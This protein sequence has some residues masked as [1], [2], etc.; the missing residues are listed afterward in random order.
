MLVCVQEFI[1]EGCL[2]KLSSK[3][4]QQRMF[5]LVFDIVIIILKLFSGMWS[6]VTKVLVLMDLGTDNRSILV[7][8]FYE[9]Y[10][11]VSCQ[12][13]ERY[14]REFHEDGIAGYTKPT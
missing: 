8:Q 6:R 10:G 1:R 5:F 9:E 7:V 12:W 11:A 3:G 13:V 4:Y 2:Q 14:G